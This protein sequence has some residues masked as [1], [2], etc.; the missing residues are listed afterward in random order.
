MGRKE[1]KKIFTERE[2]ISRLLEDFSVGKEVSLC[3]RLINKRQSSKIMFFDFRDN[4]GNIQ[5]VLDKQISI[6]SE[7]SDFLPGNYYAVAGKM[8]VTKTGEKS[9]LI[10][11]V[12]QISF[13]SQKYP[14]IIEQP[15][16]KLRQRY[17]QILSDNDLKNCLVTRSAIISAMRRYLIGKY[18][19]E[20]D[21]PLLQSNPVVGT[22][23]PFMTH[24]NYLNRDLFLRG[25]CEI[26]LKQLVV[27]GYEKIFEI[28]QVFRNES[29]S[30]IEFPLLEVQEMYK[31]YIDATFFVENML[32][33][34]YTE[35]VEKHHYVQVDATFFSN[36]PWLRLSVD[37]VLREYYSK[38]DVS[39]DSSITEE[40][41]KLGFEPKEN[42][43]LN[44]AKLIDCIIKNT[45]LRK[46]KQPVFILDYPKIVSPLAKRKSGTK[47]AERG[48]LFINGVR[49]AEVVT[50]ENDPNEQK[51][52][53]E[54]QD[55]ILGN[56]NHF[57]KDLVES[58]EYGFPIS[59]GIGLNINRL[60]SLFVGKNN[61]EMTTFFPLSMS[62]L[63]K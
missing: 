62:K 6:Y 18:F 40:L 10:R 31:D 24:S 54:L 5:V 27:A 41:I 42:A 15:N 29:E 57:H 45:I 60:V 55:Q 4:S 22:A 52:A 30:L 47:A 16:V 44:R 53:F 50:E 26:K 35:L 37:D 28:G 7:V 38:I 20:V 21:T 58:L 61:L 34:I 17:L 48:Y 56:E 32:K 2:S 1:I 43:E 59:S 12:F 23:L 25:S 39:D 14:N 46:L 19:L 11:E 8:F 63:N 9:I 36:N 51:A 49:L 3:G 33:S 13:A